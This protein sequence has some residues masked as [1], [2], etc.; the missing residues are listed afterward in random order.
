M[1]IITMVLA[2][3]SVLAAALS[4]L[5]YGVAAGVESSFGIPMGLL[6][7]SPMDLLHL[8]SVAIMELVGL[9]DDLLSFSW[10]SSLPLGGV[11][12]LSALS[13]LMYILIIFKDA[14]IFSC[15]IKIF[16]TPY[17]KTRS[18][19][20]KMREHPHLWFRLLWLPFF[21]LFT[22]FCSWLLCFSAISVSAFVGVIPAI[23]MSLA[24]HN[25]QTWPIEADVCVP[26]RTREER[27]AIHV[28]QSVPSL[29]KAS[30]C[31]A[32]IRNEAEAA[33]GRKVVGTS[34]YI[35][36]FHPVSGAAKYEPLAGASIMVVDSM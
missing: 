16:H 12:F 33:R 25:F 10:I 24:Q 1:K 4:L 15:V 7:S 26:I 31:I 36:L 34:N 28:K 20:K 21:P 14:R 18:Y 32:V 9:S 3:I 19:V 29:H 23:G 6:F 2:V 5:G 35:V 17:D 30:E 11:L 22:I 8:S 27:M 13:V